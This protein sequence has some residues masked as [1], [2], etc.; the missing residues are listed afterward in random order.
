[1]E[2]TKK[3]LPYKSLVIDRNMRTVQPSA[4]KD[5]ELIA[6]IRAEGILQNLIVAQIPGTEKYAVGAGGR[7]YSSV[8]YL[9]SSGDN[10]KGRPAND[11]T[12]LPV[13][14]VPYDQLEKY[15][16]IENHGRE[17]S[18]PADQFMAYN[19]LYR[20]GH[21]IELIATT[22]GVKKVDVKRLLKL[23]S[24]A[25]KLVELY[26]A[27]KLS[28]DA[29]MAFTISDDQD[30]Q[31]ACYE[32]LKSS[33]YDYRIRQYLTDTYMESTDSLVK[34]VGL[35]AYKKAGG[36]TA[37]DL[38]QNVTY[39]A[40]PE[41][42][43][44]LVDK[45]LERAAQKA[46][47]G[48]KWVETVHSYSAAGR[49]GRVIPAG[50]LDLP[51]ELDEQI[52]ALDAEWDELQYKS[53]DE[54]TDQDDVREAELRSLL[55][56]LEHKRETYRG[57]TDEQKA[58]C[59]VVVYVNRD[60]AAAT[61][62]CVIKPEDAKELNSGCTE[63]LGINGQK[64]NQQLESNTLAEA[65]DCYYHQSFMAEMLN[66]EQMAFDVLVY[67]MSRSLGSQ[68]CDRI[69]NIYL[70]P[71]RLASI[72]EEET[73]AQV[74][75]DQAKEALPLEC[76]EISDSV[77]RFQAFQSLT[78][79]DKRRIM[80]F[81]VARSMRSPVRSKQNELSAIRDAVKFDLTEY[82]QPTKENYFSRLK[83]KD[84]LKIGGEIE[85]EQWTDDHAKWKA[86][87]LCD[88]LPEMDS[89]KGWMPPYFK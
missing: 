68:G 29:V 13:L 60:G 55:K 42:V 78:M 77:E 25:P 10:I 46:G 4:Q 88:L 16:L 33:P 85:G 34:F 52:K 57:Y 56:E 32:A 26:R 47:K 62:A 15:S 66:H 9:I 3:E 38:F 40:N 27:G 24:V 58:N 80:T 79:T 41:I 14:E 6:T 48:W 5:K 51:P 72:E 37:G 22:F 19:Q 65:L 45:K 63:V 84:L 50:Y 36:A 2:Q 89:M 64:D 67:T 69:S 43:M 8:G 11:D 28:L 31:L 18:H 81:C 53:S 39:I 35:A 21:S 83:K 12:L 82:W 20:T 7:R 44:A 17:D 71:D 76:L 87:A 59:G 54:W 61:L 1:M 49:I 23:A 30:K 70:E 74:L 75:L 73:Q 86:G